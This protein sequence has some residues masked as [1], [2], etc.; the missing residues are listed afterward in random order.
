[1]Q[2]VKAKY[3]YAGSSIPKVF[4]G[5]NTNVSY[6]AFDLSAVFSYGLG[7]KVYAS[8]YATLM[9][10]NS[11][12]SAMHKDIEKRWQQPGDITDVPILDAS[13]S[14]NQN[15]ASD[16]WLKNG[17]YLNMRSLT[18][19]YTL[20]RSFISPAGIYNAR[21]SF[22]AENLFT[23]SALKGLDPQQQYTGVVDNAFIQSRAFTLGLSLTL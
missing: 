10:V 6:K 23:V 8:A 19:A 2:E 12:G 16:R 21:V 9:S 15:G 18:L 11:Y 3:H 17:N 1:M 22:S 7:G 4:G 14:T 20:P 13:Q 5:F